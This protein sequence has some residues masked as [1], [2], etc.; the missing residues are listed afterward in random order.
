MSTTAD[1]PS[2]YSAWLRLFDDVVSQLPASEQ[3]ALVARLGP[4]PQADRRAIRERLTA[5]VELVAN[6]SWRTYDQYLKSQ[7]VSEGVESY[8][9]VVDLLLGSAALDWK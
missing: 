7:G 2:R 9:R 3:R 5:R 4:G 6:V 8:S 1:A